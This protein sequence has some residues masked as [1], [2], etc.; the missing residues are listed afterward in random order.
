MTEV[1]FLAPAEEEM[2]AAAAYYDSQAEGLGDNFLAEVQY[3]AERIA[4]NPQ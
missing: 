2:R 4:E 1:V 3:T